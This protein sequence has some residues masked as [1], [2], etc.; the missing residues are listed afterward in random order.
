MNGRTALIGALLAI[1][2]GL[3][4]IFGP[5]LGLRGS[6]EVPA[7]TP[8]AGDASAARDAAAAPA[9][10]PSA[11]SPPAPARPAIAPVAVRIGREP[12]LD[13]CPSAGKVT[14]LKAQG[15][16]FVAVRAAPDVRAGEIDRLGPDAMVY[17]CEA[18]PDERWY[19]IVYAPGG[20]LGDGCSVT[21]PVARPA[22]YRGSCRS[23]W[24]SRNYVQLVAG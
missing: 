6:S 23:G 8:P 11:L 22:D 3:F 9:A 10:S 24:A 7:A 19:G 4:L 18:S 20:T 5:G 15:D 12:E 13:A 2:I 17:I 16:N 1:V 21:S 14:N